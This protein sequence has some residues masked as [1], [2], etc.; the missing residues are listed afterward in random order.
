[1]QGIHCPSDRP[2]APKRLGDARIAEG[3]YAWRKLLA[4][5]ARILNGTDAPVE[6][7]SPDPELPRHG[8]AAGRRRPAAGRL[9]PRPEARRASEALRTMTLDAA[10]GSFAERERG[11]IE[12][13]QARRPRRALAGHP[14]G[15]RRRAPEDRGVATIVDGRRALREG[16]P[17]RP[18]FR[19]PAAV[20]A[21]RGG[22]HGRRATPDT[23]SSTRACPSPGS[24]CSSSGVTVAPAALALAWTALGLALFGWVAEADGLPWRGRGGSRSAATAAGRAPLAFSVRHAGRRAALQPRGGLERRRLVER[25]TRCASG[26]GAA[27]RPRCELR[28]SPAA[29]GRCAGARRSSE[30]RFEH[31][32]RVSYV[33]RRSRSSG[34]A[35]AGLT[36]ERA[37][38]ADVSRS[39]RS[40]RGGDA[41]SRRASSLVEPVPRLTRFASSRQPPGTPAGTWRKSASPT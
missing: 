21:S 19:A 25:S 15:P 9:R 1:M 36:G 27:R 34:R 8:H 28:R 24:C 17:E 14:V 40:G 31:H 16:S 4:T 35:G 39:S 30:L 32:E 23:G 20:V 12:V 2:W 11:S 29:A 22:G 33:D 10:Y 6:D 41:G 5:G 3:A 7:V 26:R 38:A 13:G 37:T 18:T